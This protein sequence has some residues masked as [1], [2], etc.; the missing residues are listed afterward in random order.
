MTNIQ[1]K[2]SEL[3][4]G[5]T[6]CLAELKRSEERLEKA[7]AKT[8]EIAEGGGSTEDIL[9]AL[10]SERM[11]VMN[12]PEVTRELARHTEELE[13]LVRKIGEL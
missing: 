6:K 7:R 4:A 1:K 10:L 2:L 13:T 12:R 9:E 3:I 11:A 8:V 5:R